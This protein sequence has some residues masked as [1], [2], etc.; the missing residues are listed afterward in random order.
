MRV[1]RKKDR[2]KSFHEQR[3]AFANLFERIFD[4]ADTRLYT[5]PDGNF[6]HASIRTLLKQLR[7][8]KVQGQLRESN[9]QLLVQ[10]NN[11]GELAALMFQWGQEA[12]LSEKELVE[13]MNDETNRE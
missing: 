13:K 9:G 11:L 6:Y 7:E 4:A 12:G 5:L 1:L 10:F 2:C 8:C 3:E